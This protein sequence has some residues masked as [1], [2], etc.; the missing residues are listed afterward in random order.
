MKL[1][2][3]LA[4]MGPY[5]LGRASHGQTLRS[6]LGEQAGAGD[7]RR[8]HIY[9]EFCRQH[10]LDAVGHVFAYCRSAVAAHASAAT[11][12]GLVDRYFHAHPMHHFEL[13]WNGRHFPAFVAQLLPESRD[14]LPGFLPE[15]ADF[16]WWEWQTYSAPDDPR[17]ESPASGELRVA[18]TVELRPYGYDL[19][20]WI[21]GREAHR[22]ASTPDISPSAV[23]FWR[24]RDLDLRCAPANPLELMILKAVVERI[25]LDHEFT[26]QV[27]LPADVVHA[28]VSDLHAAGILYGVVPQ[29]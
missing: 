21:D 11:W 22:F 29:P 5:L 20:A 1:A 17:D 23:L 16:E 25:L 6:L 3:L 8:L 2:D 7:G 24:D 18:S 4:T 10:R 27:G 15:L 14:K 13:N 19:L 12:E 28:C 26:R 9:G